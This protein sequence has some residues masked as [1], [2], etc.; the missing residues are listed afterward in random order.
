MR[1]EEFNQLLETKDVLSAYEEI[2]T[3]FMQELSQQLIEEE[4]L[5]LTIID[6]IG[7]LETAKDFEKLIDFWKHLEQYQPQFYKEELSIYYTGTLVEYFSYQKNLEKLVVAMDYFRNDP[8]KDYDVFLRTTR[9]LV[10]YGYKDILKDLILAVYPKVLE[11]PDLEEESFPE[12]TDILFNIELENL[13]YS[14]KDVDEIDFKP[15][16]TI[17]EE[18]EVE[19]EPDFFETIL[20][21]VK[22]RGLGEITTEESDG[23][24]SAK[25]IDETLAM[26][27]Y[28]FLDYM[29]QKDVPFFISSDIWDNILP[30]WQRKPNKLI[31]KLEKRSYEQFMNEKTGFIIDY[32]M[33]IFA[34]VWGS[35]YVY[36]FLN[37][38]KI[39][40]EETYRQALGIIESTKNDLKEIRPDLWKFSFVHNWSKPMDIA[41]ETWEEEQKL[42][43][44]NFTHKEDYKFEPIFQK[45]DES[46]D[47]EE[48]LEELETFFEQKEVPPKVEIKEKIGRN[49]MVKV[50]YINGT[51]KEVKF[52]KVKA[53]IENGECELL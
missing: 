4:D 46:L 26:F 16:L 40:K 7:E 33:D 41:M 37:A 29:R 9:F 8:T 45:E 27:K 13:F 39:I 2:K 38:L 47:I 51:I 43:E 42:F 30:Y 36:E 14:S 23:L 19:L 22:N 12:L 44:D 21:K 52:K 35:V 31:F 5:V 3:F 17:A 15:L 18:Y 53:D 10:Y 25:T 1:L 34:S 48:A 6:I 11:D 50:K 20:P 28:L 32:T 24:K 49:E